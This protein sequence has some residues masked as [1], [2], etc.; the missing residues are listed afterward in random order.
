MRVASSIVVNIRPPA[1]QIDGV[2]YP[3]EKPRRAERRAYQARQKEGRS[4]F[5]QASDCFA[6]VLGQ[7]GAQH[8][9]HRKA[10]HDHRVAVPAQAFKSIDR[11]FIPLRMSGRTKFFRSA[12]MTGDADT[13]DPYTR[14]RELLAEIAHLERRPAKPVDQQRAYAVSRKKEFPCIYS[15]VFGVGIIV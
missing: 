4:Q 14:G 1:A 2:A 3:A 8:S 13:A 6:L 5:H 11:G 15:R 7:A 12:R 10:H 9:T